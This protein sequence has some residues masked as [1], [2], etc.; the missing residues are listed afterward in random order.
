MLKE[1]SA[2]G[3]AFEIAAAFACAHAAIPEFS[4]SCVS[5]FSGH[6]TDVCLSLRDAKKVHIIFPV[7]CARP[8]III[9]WSTTTINELKSLWIQAK[10]YK[11]P[12][13]GDDLEYA[14]A[15]TDPSL[16]YTKRD[17]SEYKV[18]AHRRKLVLKWLETHKSGVDRILL[19]QVKHVDIAPVKSWDAT[20]KPKLFTAFYEKNL[21]E[22][23]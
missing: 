11:T 20:T 14:T 3:F 13:S 7:K 5:I 1:P 9:V 19:C 21:W 12:L 8:D 17:G 10:F 2:Q 4:L 18:H 15:T 6:V 22:L 16:I 23:K